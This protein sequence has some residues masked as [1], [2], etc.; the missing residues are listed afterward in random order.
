[1]EARGVSGPSFMFETGSANAWLMRLYGKTTLEPITNSLCYVIYKMLPNNTDFTVFKAA[2]YQGF[3]LAFIGDVGHYHTPL[4]NWENSSASTMQH[5]GANALSALLA[6]A[7]SPDLN[8]PASN[9]MF[10]DVL[11]RSVIVWPIE[12]RP[13]CGARR[14]G[15]I[16]GSRRAA[17]AQGILE[18]RPSRVWILRRARSM[19]CWAA[20]SAWACSFCC[21]F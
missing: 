10:F 3:N 12:L 5:Q 19:F 2:A 16:A 18:L 20:R 6:L 14:A 13:A 15:A 21:G 17:D 1:M 7:N 9:S 8:H 4:D 11:A